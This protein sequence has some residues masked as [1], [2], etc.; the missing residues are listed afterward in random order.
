MLHDA[1]GDQ[2]AWMDDIFVTGLEGDLVDLPS[3]SQGEQTSARY[4]GVA[5]VC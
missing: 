3:S 1:V 5:P 4:E 2:V